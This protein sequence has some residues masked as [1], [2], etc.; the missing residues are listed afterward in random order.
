MWADP[1]NWIGGITPFID[2]ILFGNAPGTEVE[3]VDVD[4]YGDN[5]L[6]YAASLWFEA[7][8]SYRF[9]S[10]FSPIILNGG[11]PDNYLVVVHSDGTKQS[12]V[13]IEPDIWVLDGPSDWGLIENYS[14]GGLSFDG[15]FVL[16][17]KDIRFGGT[18][19]IRLRGEII[20]AGGNDPNGSIEVGGNP[21]WGNQ[22]HLV[23]GGHNAEWGGSLLVQDRGF[24]IIKGDQALGK[25]S[26]KNVY[27]GGTLGLRSHRQLPLTYI[28]PGKADAIQVRGTGIRRSE[29]THRV[30]AIFN[31]GG[32]NAF[33]VRIDMIP[34]SQ[35]GPVGFGARG[36]RDGGLDLKNQIQGK[37]V[38][39]LKIGPGLIILSNQGWDDTENQ[40]DK[41]T[42]LAGGV[43]R[44]GN[45]KS[46]PTDSNLVLSGGI[47]ELGYNGFLRELGTGKDQLRW[48]GSGGFSAH[49]ADRSITL[50]SDTLT[51]ASTQHFLRDGHA[52]LLS[53]RYADHAITLTNAIDLNSALREVRV[54]RGSPNAHAVL[55][56]SLGSS[57]GGAG[58][59]IK[60]GDGLLWLKSEN[61]Y[62]GATVIRGGA[63]RGHQLASN[64][65]QNGTNIELAG[66]VLG[67]NSN[68]TSFTRSLGTGGNQIRW[69][70]SGGFAA[71]GGGGVR[72]FLG[73]SSNVVNWG[74]AHF[75]QNGT[76]LR[77]GHYTANG[78]IYWE[79][80]LGL[81]NA[82]RTI[83]IERGQ[84][85]G[86]DVELR[87]QLT[88]GSLSKL[89]LV[90]DGRIDITRASWGLLSD[91]VSIHGA[92][93]HLNDRGVLG[94]VAGFDIRHGGSLVLDNTASGH[95]YNRIALD[96]AI[97]LAAGTLTLSTGNASV[98]EKMGDLTLESGANTLGLSRDLFLAHSTELYAEKLVRDGD[99]RA[100]LH[101]DANLSDSLLRLRLNQLPT[102]GA[103]ANITI[104]GSIIADII[105]WATT[106]YGNHYD[107]WL[108]PTEI[109]DG[110]FYL[111]GLPEA[112]FKSAQSSL[113]WADVVDDNVNTT[114][115]IQPL[116]LDNDRSINSLILYRDLNL[117]AH[118]L[119][120]NSGGL[121][122][123]DRPT[124]DGNATRTIFGLPL[125]TST[126]TT[127]SAS[128]PLYIHNSGQLT[129]TT[130]V[131]I[132]GGMDLV[133]TRGGTLALQSRGTH[134]VGSVYIHQGT[135]DLRDGNI[136]VG[137]GADQ[138]IIIGDGAG[139]DRL[140]LPGHRVEP[141]VK[142]GGGSPSITLRG[143]P[144]D[145]R[146]P[147]Y[148]G[149]QAILQL[150]GD[151]NGNT[152]QH[153]ANLH[154][155]H[156]G[157][158]DFRGGEFG[159]AN[160]LWLDTLTFNN[161]DA[162]LFIRNWYEFEDM[163]LVRKSWF[164]GQTQEQRAKLL[165]QVVF[166]G[167]QD[168]RTTWK[169]YD[170]DYI[171]IYA[172]SYFP[173]PSTYGAIL[174]AV[175]LGLVVWQKRRNSRR[176]CAS[177]PPR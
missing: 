35:G 174:G 5:Y 25:V 60:T 115:N 164:N 112:D 80:G 131:V 2:H 47:L 165:S 68:G 92:Q 22:P 34:D 152:K 48:T 69:T 148:G 45:A 155:E 149:D 39:F 132:S 66:G 90:G 172:F 134:Q 21:L 147:E 40:W 153:L 96:T 3:W 117:N 19:G 163:L 82:L 168:Y 87:G 170:N 99:S 33:D 129:L 162:Q 63:L 151:Q 177:R 9:T 138:R 14:Q 97:T 124:G 110:K 119:T 125:T 76:E 28:R 101:V 106:Y 107:T 46:L 109:N 146:G 145:P 77:F 30:G 67:I 157:T 58:G 43:L 52:L 24:A 176:K 94:A 8:T 160:I 50:G 12:E 141:I 122:V 37:N 51:W 84:Q 1:D 140:I 136:E 15:N 53:S 108:V 23:L 93:L 4:F 88:G 64:G 158:I 126:I 6:A 10:Y 55:S 166:E 75:V 59:L 169:A 38:G 121:M 114:S 86:A 72:I 105:P 89:Y 78:T 49:G 81:G 62:T 130:G 159:H 41:E 120:I 26:G 74:A 133:K 111:K 7:G 65:L 54:E 128:R 144:Y 71:Y 173:E 102:M 42:T 135:I 73:A 156:R 56:G 20:G 123:S 36:D 167:Y 17:D 100:T 79:N 32:K 118:T 61:T 103:F 70:G 116:D 18:G 29:D 31:D 154:I 16:G 104:G 127:K 83:R 137:S 142:A 85:A 44:L 91:S 175:G 98:S 13:S 27:E 95:T 139:T 143:T 11:A 57:G 150:G 171:Q 113:S 161:A